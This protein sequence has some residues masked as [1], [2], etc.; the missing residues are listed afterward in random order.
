MNQQLTLHRR[1]EHFHYKKLL[2]RALQ[3]VFCNENVNL[4]KMAGWFISTLTGR[5]VVTAD[6]G[7]FPVAVDCYCAIE[8][9]PQIH[10]PV[11]RHRQRHKPFK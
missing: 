11:R 2:S 5:F 8:L 1:S 9:T 10:N 6:T 7:G 3:G 4:R